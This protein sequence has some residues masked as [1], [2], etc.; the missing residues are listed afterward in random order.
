MNKL[1]SIIWLVPMLLLLGCSDNYVDDLNGTYDLPRYNFTKAKSNETTKLA[2]GLK[3]LNID[4]SNDNGDSF[5]LLV[6]TREW[7]LQ[8]GSYQVAG[9]AAEPGA[10]MT[11]FGTGNAG[12]VVP[13]SGTLYVVK[14]GDEYIINGLFGEVADPEKKFQ[15][16]YRGAIEFEIGIDDPEPSGYNVT[17]VKTQ[18]TLTDPVTYQP[19]PLEGLSKYTFTITDPNGS[20]AGCI[21]ALNATDIEMTGMAGEY[22]IQGNPDKAWL[23]DNGWVVPDWG[24]AGGTYFVD[25]TANRRYITSGKFNIEF[26]NGINGEQLVNFTGSSLASINADGSQAEAFNLSIKFAQLLV[27][28]GTEIR[29]LKI[30]S[31]TLGREMTYSVLLP[32]G[33]DGNKTYPVLYMLHGAYGNNNDWLQQGMVA[34]HIASAGRDMVIVF[35]NA[36]IDGFDTFYVNNYQNKGVQY[37]DYFF[38][39]LLPTVEAMFNVKPGKENRGIAG[40]SMGGYGSLYYGLSRADMFS[41]IYACSPAT[42]MEGTPNIYDM[43]WVPGLP[44]ITVEIG[45]ADYLYE[46]SLGFLEA[47]K[48]SQIN[49][50]FIEREGAHDWAFWTACTPKILKKFAEIFPE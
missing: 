14:N 30:Q 25:N 45:T 35:P 19:I 12:S 50:D 31:E 42:Y 38:N 44:G 29:D 2:K 28:S 34:A 3:R 33:F 22:T 23:A 48:Y 47:L 41:Y 36:T 15:L 18:A 27:N 8:P 9:S 5:N 6:V 26:V 43:M 7:V 32:D 4:F 1:Y 17:V 46:S 11:F 24:M 13:G 49:W 20:N 37:E 16:N 21:E 10:D 39:E 40:L